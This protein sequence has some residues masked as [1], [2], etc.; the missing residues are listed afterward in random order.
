MVVIDRGIV[1]ASQVLASR[2]GAQI[3][4]EG[5]SAIDARE[6]GDV[7]VGFGIM[8]GSNQPLAHAEF[9]SDVVD[10]D[11]N[12]QA[13]LSARRAMMGRGQAVLHNSKTSGNFGAS[14]PRAHGA[15]EPEP[16]PLE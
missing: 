10:Y 9:V 5:G 7:R 12:I 1:A 8:G 2:A 4:A 14:D 13:A 16:I 6:R 3:L 11:M 15:A